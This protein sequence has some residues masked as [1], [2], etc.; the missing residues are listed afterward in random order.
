[1]RDFLR[2]VLTH[3]DQTK[4]AAR[5]R[6]R[7]ALL[8]DRIDLSGGSMES[9]RKDVLTVLSRYMVVGNDFQEFD[10]HRSDDAVYLVSNIKV[11]E[12]IS[13]F[14]PSNF[15]NPPAELPINACGVPLL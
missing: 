8:K 14:E 9:L 1:M 11:E 7:L 15:K 2:W 6:L 4:E 3:K 5:D 12:L 10:I 13:T